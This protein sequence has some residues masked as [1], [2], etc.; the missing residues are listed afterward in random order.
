MKLVF[1]N[2]NKRWSIDTVQHNKQDERR[3]DVEKRKKRPH[4]EGRSMQ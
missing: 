3:E 2:I 4:F 1:T